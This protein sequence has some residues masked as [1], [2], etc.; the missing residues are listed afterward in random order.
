[1]GHAEIDQSGFLAAVDHIDRAS[2]DFPGRFG[3]AVAILCLAQ[4]VGADYPYF[5][6]LDALKKLCEARQAVEAA[7]DGVIRES[8]V[9]QSCAQLHLF[10]EHLYGPH[11]AVLDTGDNQV[12]G[13]AAK[14]YCSQLAA[15]RK[16]FGVIAVQSVPFPCLGGYLMVLEGV[17]GVQPEPWSQ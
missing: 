1:M 11:L 2:K 14:I 16:V 15:F 5:F 9:F 17:S 12:E 3:E 10:G 7:F 6:W 4:R 13:V 8:T